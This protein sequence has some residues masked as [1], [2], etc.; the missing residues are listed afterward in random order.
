MEGRWKLLIENVYFNLSRCFRALRDQTLDLREIKAAVAATAEGY[1]FPT[2]S[3]MIQKE[4]STR[5]AASSFHES[6]ENNMTQ[7]E[8]ERILNE[9][10]A[11]RLS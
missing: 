8:F 7:D 11:V 2:N 5:D 9:M 6:L 4:A 10:E 3:I 1:S